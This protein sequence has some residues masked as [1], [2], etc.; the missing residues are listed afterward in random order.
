[1]VYSFVQIL[2]LCSLTFAYLT[3]AINLIWQYNIIHVTTVFVNM[4]FSDEDKISKIK[5]QYLRTTM[6]CLQL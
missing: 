4:A 2:S 5:C 1:M 3:L 6:C